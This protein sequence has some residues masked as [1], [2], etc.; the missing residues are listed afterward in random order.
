MRETKQ[1]SPASHQA[2]PMK[3]PPSTNQNRL[4]KKRKKD[5]WVTPAAR[6]LAVTIASPAGGRN[7]TGEKVDN[8]GRSTPFLCPIGGGWRSKWPVYREKE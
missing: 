3:T 7:G 8:L 1:S 5:M 2:S 6:E 4:N